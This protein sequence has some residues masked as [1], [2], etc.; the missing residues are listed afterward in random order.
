MSAGLNPADFWTVTPREAGIILTGAA[1]RD[2]RQLRQGQGLV[3]TLAALVAYAV[4][5]PSKM[6]KFDKVF[7]DGKPKKAQ[8]PEEIL[9]A[10]R[11]WTAVIGAVKG[12]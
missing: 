6:P 3:Y 9:A 5:N 1:A 8:S 2:W 11:E 10:M 4:N 12:D 7:P